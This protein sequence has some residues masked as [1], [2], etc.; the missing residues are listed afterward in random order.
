MVCLWMGLAR[1][2][3]CGV[4]STLLTWVP[5]ME[6]RSLGLHGQQLYALSRPVNPL[7]FQFARAEMLFY[8]DD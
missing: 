7:S 5:R 1:G 4:R 3:L 8:K 2:Q 6:L